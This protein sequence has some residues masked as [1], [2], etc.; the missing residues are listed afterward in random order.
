MSVAS[1]IPEEGVEACLKR[2]LQGAEIPAFSRQIQELM[3]ALSDN[4]ASTQWLANAVLKNYSL[5]LKVIRA[6]NTL[7]YNRTGTRVRS[8]TQA[9][10]LIGTRAVGELAGSQ[11]LFEHYGKRSP[12]LKQLMLL[13]MLTANHARALAVMLRLNGLEEAYL[14]GMFRN[15]GEVLVACHLEREYALI[16]KEIEEHHR[17]PADACFHILNFRYEALGRAMA[18]HWSMPAA[19]QQALAPGAARAD[20]L[21]A[22]TAFSHELSFTVYRQDPESARA[23]VPQLLE[24][25]GRQL[26]LDEDKVRTILEKAVTETQAT[27]AMVGLSLDDLRLR[28]QIERTLPRRPDADVGGDERAAAEPA[29]GPAT[30]AQLVAEVES[31]LTRADAG[32]DLNR[33]LLMVLEGVYRGGPF[34]R[35]AF[36]LATGDRSEVQGRF[37]I[38]E[39]FEG[40]VQRF[41]YAVSARGGPI[42]AALARRAE[43]IVW[44]EGSPT[45]PELDLLD[46][47]AVHGLGVYPLVVHDLLV[48]CLYFDVLTPQRPPDPATRAFLD[49]L[50]ACAVRAIALRRPP[51]QSHDLP[52]AQKGQIVLRLLRGEAAEVVCRETRIP[53]VQLEQWRQAFIEG[54]IGHLG[55]EA[56]TEQ[57]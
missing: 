51:P 29:E 12:G 40:L 23:A 4:E 3:R 21:A 13:S 33:A 24:R 57:P 56:G 46:A 54:G 16:L 38:G 47:L 11:L 17:T 48:G 42:G 43:L 19:V 35:A 18:R 55:P 52:P 8:V 10:L 26:S 25:F 39:D 31:V 50:R 5:T 1:E 30:R 15:L 28:R 7:Q 20:M 53:V 14:C 37:G 27:F 6:G 45:R 36:A 32:L 22:I 49:R 34:D 41:R 9:M 44:R 2:I